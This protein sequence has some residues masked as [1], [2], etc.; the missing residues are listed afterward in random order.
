M[1]KLF[2]IFLL[3]FIAPSFADYMENIPNKCG[4][5]IG[6]FNAVF[7]PNQYVCNNGEF[8]PADS[9]ECKPCPDDYICDGGIFTFNE[10][11]HSG[12]KKS[13]TYINNSL[14]N[15]CSLNV[16]HGF[17]A[18]FTINSYDCVP[19][20]YLPAGND[21]LTDDQGCT[22]CPA[23]NYCVGGIFTFNETETQG[24]TPCPNGTISKAGATA[25]YPHILHIDDDIIYLK[26]TKKT[27]PSLNIGMDD[28]IFYANMTTVPTPMNAA[29]DHYLKIEY[30]GVIYYVCD[31]TVY[32]E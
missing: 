5:I 20:Y 24:I 23:D 9:L 22:I 28:G 1:N 7:T 31:D 15:M 21:W 26:S 2:Y 19:G 29:T 3:L 4:N 17:E 32:K 13:Q 14:N 18:I 12:A 6:S 25:C 27:V 16:F 11:R 8:L 10:Y 30:D